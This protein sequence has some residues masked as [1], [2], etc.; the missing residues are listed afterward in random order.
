MHLVKSKI[1]IDGILFGVGVTLAVNIPLIF[2]FCINAALH[3]LLSFS[4]SFKSVP[5]AIRYVFPST[6]FK[7]KSIIVSEK[8]IYSSITFP[9]I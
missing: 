6:S 1:L 9:E 8:G 7:S 2:S 4:G 5:T 3:S